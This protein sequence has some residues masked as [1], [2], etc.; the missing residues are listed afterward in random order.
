MDTSRRILPAQQAML[1]QGTSRAPFFMTE[2]SLVLLRLFFRTPGSRQ[3]RRG[4]RLREDYRESPYPVSEFLEDL[5]SLTS[6]DAMVAIAI[7][8]YGTLF[9]TAWRWFEKE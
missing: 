4:T 3:D 5:Y 6:D 1:P 2:L 8:V 9:A 7:L